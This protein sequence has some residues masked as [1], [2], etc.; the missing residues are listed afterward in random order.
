MTHLVTAHIIAQRFKIT[1]FTAPL[2]LAP[3]RYKRTRAQSSQLSFAGA[4]HVRI[5]LDGVG[6]AHARLTP[7]QPPARKITHRNQTE[8]ETTA[9]WRSQAINHG[10]SR[11]RVNVDTRFAGPGQ[12]HLRWIFVFDNQ[13]DVARRVVSD[14]DAHLCFGP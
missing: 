10:R 8:F 9:F 5:N 1:S 6:R 12:L 4:P 11:L 13:R 3:R 7:Y 14:L 2:R